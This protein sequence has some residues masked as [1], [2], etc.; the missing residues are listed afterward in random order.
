MIATAS[1]AGQIARELTVADH[2]IDMEIELK[3]D[4]VSE[5]SGGEATGRKLYPQLKSGDSHLERR[6]D[7]REV[8]RIKEARHAEYW[9]EQRFPVMLVIRT[10]D[11]VIRWM[12]IREYLRR[13]SQ[14]GKKLVR[15]IVFEGERST[16]RACGAGGTGRCVWRTCSGSARALRRHRTRS[17]LAW[18]HSSRPG[19]Y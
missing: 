9:R 12:E 4:P 17:A 3:R 2:G 15:Q 10:S 18:R 8:F 7:G 16:C 6:R 11:G 1:Q 19:D 14:G 13:V 5:R